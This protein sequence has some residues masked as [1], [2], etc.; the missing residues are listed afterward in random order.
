MRPADGV[1]GW[2]FAGIGTLVA[3]SLM[4]AIGA[5][6]RLRVWLWLSIVGLVLTPAFFGYAT[7]NWWG[8][9]IGHLGAAFVALG[10]TRARPIA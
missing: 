5:L 7:E 4:V 3:S 9:T 8:A 2:A 10:G 6:V 1:N